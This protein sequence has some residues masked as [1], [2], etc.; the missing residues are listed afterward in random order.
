MINEE[1][2]DLILQ[3]PEHLLVDNSDA[4]SDHDGLHIVGANLEKYTGKDSSSYL[5]TKSWP[6]LEWDHQEKH[7]QLDWQIFQ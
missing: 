7:D 2:D 1:V 5:A 4:E 6:W 3:A